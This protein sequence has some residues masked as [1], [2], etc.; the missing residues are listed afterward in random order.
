[1]HAALVH[2]Q[3][4]AIHPFLDG[5]GRVGRLL[6]TLLLVAKQIMPAPLLY[7]SA[8]FE[9][10]QPEYYARL[11]GVTTRGEWEEWL[12]YFL[13]GVSAQAEDAVS[14]VQRM[15]DLLAQWRAASAGARSQTVSGAIE[16]FVENPFWTV[17]GVAGRLGVAF[18][19]AQRAIDRLERAGIIALEREARRNRLYCAR[20]LLEILEEPSRRDE[21]RPAGR[22]TPPEARSRKPG[23]ES[24]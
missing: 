20:G 6:I 4:E 21:R 15:T 14:R 13:V 8:Y 7:L 12:T 22:R 2:S 24:R 3:F 16:L 19:T 10:T 17:K 18:T 23:A 9:S 11:Q 5:N 1:M